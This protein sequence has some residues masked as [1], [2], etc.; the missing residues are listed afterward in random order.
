MTENDY[1][2]IS[3]QRRVRILTRILASA[4]ATREKKLLAMMGLATM[5]RFLTFKV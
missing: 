2:D 4:T 1:R 5:A 3:D